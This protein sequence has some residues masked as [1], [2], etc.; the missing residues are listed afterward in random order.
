M[1]RL[2]RDTYVAIV[3][4]LVCGVF[5]WATFDIR[6]PNYGTLMPSTWPRVILGVLSL[7][8]LVFLIQSLRQPSDEAGSEPGK[9]RDPGIQGWLAYWRNPIAC[10]AL[11]FLFLLTLPVLGMLIGGV[12]FVFLL[13]GTLGGWSRR[14][15][16][17]HALIAVCTV[18]A[19]WSLFTFGLGV[20]LPTGIIFNPF[21]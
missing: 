3:L 18:G 7:L 12:S 10:F 13:M 9:E 17:V 4:L 20:I 14:N 21:G 5:F 11:F 1:V 19:M 2:N 8:S 15:V 6:Q 16:I